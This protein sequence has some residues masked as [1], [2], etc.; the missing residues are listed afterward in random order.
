MYEA[1]VIRDFTFE[2]FK[3]HGVFKK[4]EIIKDL[5]KADIDFLSGNNRYHGTFIDNVREIV[6]EAVKSEEV[7]TA[8][9]KTTTRKTTSKKK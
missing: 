9:K 3:E 2:T 5:T 4:G 7:E 6:E 8:T 1:R